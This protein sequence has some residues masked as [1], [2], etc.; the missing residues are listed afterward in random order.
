M[1]RYRPAISCGREPIRLRP[2]MRAACLLQVGQHVTRRILAAILFMA[3]SGLAVAQ[4]QKASFKELPD[5]VLDGKVLLQS[6]AGVKVDPARCRQTCLETAGCAGFTAYP[7]GRCLIFSG[8]TQQRTAAAGA[9]SAMAATTSSTEETGRSSNPQAGVVQ[10]SATATCPSRYRPI[11]NQT[12]VGGDLSLRGL[13]VSFERCA[14]LCIERKE[15]AAFA[16]AG[17]PETQH[18][19]D[20]CQLKSR[21]RP[22]VDSAGAL[23]CER[24]DDQ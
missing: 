18:R 15:C 8:V 5:V 22:M 13:A 9:V 19:D 21:L 20:K 12:I 23:L 10:L 7:D 2:A 14:E 1:T 17:G 4:D 24:A 3:G 16:W 11:P 6:R